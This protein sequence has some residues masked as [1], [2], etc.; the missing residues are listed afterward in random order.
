MKKSELRKLIKQVLQEQTFT[1]FS[2]DE[3]K[4]CEA[5]DTTSDSERPFWRKWCCNRGW[6][7]CQRK[8]PKRMN[9][10]WD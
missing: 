2:P 5:W 8:R 1:K 10:C 7:C 4:H 3:Q 9:P 6:R